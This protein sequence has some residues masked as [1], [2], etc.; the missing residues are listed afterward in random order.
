VAAAED[1]NGDGSGDVIVGAPY[2]DPNGRD[3]A[4]QVH[5]VY[6]TDNGFPAN[7][8]LGALNGASGFTINGA[9]GGDQAG[10]AVSGAG[11][12]NGDGMD[13]VVIG[14]RTASARTVDRVAS[15]TSCSAPQRWHRNSSFT[16]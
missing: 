7:I 15:P 4:G 9:A 14:T 6:G 10:F 13:D 1:V 12:F 8:E 5:V 16:R 11:D 2:A 3:K